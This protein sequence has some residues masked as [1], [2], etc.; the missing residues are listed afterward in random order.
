VVLEDKGF[1]VTSKVG[2]ALLWSK[3]KD[4][5]SATVIGIQERGLYKV[6]DH[7]IQ[8]LIHDEVN[9]NELWHQRFGHLHYKAL[10][11]LQKMVKGMPDF[12]FKH[13]GICRGCALGKN[14][15]K[16]FP[17]SDKRSKGILDLIHSDTCGPMSTPSM[18][19]CSYY[20]IFIDNFSRKTWIYFLKSKN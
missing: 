8:A 10:P 2:K 14:A 15:K 16:T 4:L 17:N 13:D 5:S 18:S 20:M 1:R 11:G 19:G 6:P 12:H 7:P 3:D 9:P